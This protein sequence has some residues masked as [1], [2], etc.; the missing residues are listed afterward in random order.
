[1][2][3][4][5]RA[6]QAPVL[7]GPARLYETP[8]LLDVEEAASCWFACITGGSGGGAEEPASDTQLVQ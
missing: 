4:I 3:N 2:E 7:E 6:Y 5:V 8:L 1:M